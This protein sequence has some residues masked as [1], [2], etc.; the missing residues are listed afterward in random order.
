MSRHAL[1]FYL[2]YLMPLLGLLIVV[3]ALITTQVVRTQ[4][5]LLDRELE[6]SAATTASDLASRSEVSILL[7]DTTSLAAEL[8]RALSAN[9][10]AD[11]LS[12]LDSSGAVIVEFGSA[13]SLVGASRGPLPSPI[14]HVADHV[15]AVSLIRG[16]NGAL[17][18]ESVA[19]VRT[20][21]VRAVVRRATVRLL[22]VSAIG[23][24]AV[25]LSAG[26]LLRRIEVL[27]STLEQRVN[28][29]THD[30][31]QKTA[32]V[33][34]TALF[35][36]LNPSPVIRFD[37]Q[38]VIIWANTE[39][40]RLLDQFA[41]GDVSVSR[42]FPVLADLDLATLIDADL[43]ALRDVTH[44]QQTFQVSIRGVAAHNFGHAYFA[45]I[46][47]QKRSETALAD[48]RDRAL[49]ASRMK[50]QFLANM[51][52]E[53]RTPMNGVLGMLDLLST[54]VLT[55]KQGEFV[56]LASSSAHGLLIIINDILDFSK[57]EAGRMD[58]ERI[59]FDLRETVEAVA[60]LLAEPAHAKGL[61]LACCIAPEIPQ[62][63][64]GDSVRLRQ[65]LL[66]LG[67]NGVKFTASGVVR[68]DVE[69]PRR[70]RDHAHI[71]FAITDTGIGMSADTMDRLFEPFTQADS[72]TTR[73][74]GGTGLGLS[75]SR[76]L[77]EL[78][79]GVLRVDSTEGTGSTFQ[80]S[81]GMA[82]A[83][84]AEL[85]GGAPSLNGMRV[86]VVDDNEIR[87]DTL[88]RYLKSEGSLIA[89]ADCTANALAYLAGSPDALP[90]IVIV[91]E[92]LAEGGA[93]AL[94]RS[95][96]E[97]PR[98]AP[99]RMVQVAATGTDAN[100]SQHGA[101]F[102]AHIHSPLRYREM[103]ATL[104]ALRSSA[105][106]TPAP[107]FKTGET[108]HLATNSSLNGHNV[109]A[110][111][112]S[113]RVLLAEDNKVN[114]FLAVEILQYAGYLVD[115][116]ENGQEA[117]DARFGAEYAAILMDCQMPVMDGLSAARAIRARES[118]QR[119]SRIP[120]VAL[121]A[122]AQKEDLRA[123]MDAG[124]DAYLSKPYTPSA[125]LTTLH[126]TL[127]ARY[128]DESSNVSATPRGSR[129]SC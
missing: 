33:A 31:A 92:R 89:T 86:L 44:R 95:I 35:A 4:R 98:F 85:G 8:R 50:S 105:P 17:L 48:A 103:M 57:I 112:G 12:V 129:A 99:I 24:L 59:P 49:D 93:V 3:F 43:R 67:G 128:R 75:I 20:A 123:S 64:V 18:G 84:E 25:A 13:P 70:E 127:R 108:V 62:F 87:R 115:V 65:I 46:S 51:S 5:T 107:S 96:R 21:R 58:M 125:L 55:D 102:D 121:T 81:I 10:D 80:F 14:R 104:T 41:S 120:I 116:V 29:R 91:S 26:V 118:A 2:R 40:D 38:G 69:I 60:R 90:E 52:H 111:P 113:T 30:L 32:E 77:V 16:S 56:H 79:G 36:T 114:Q 66:N 72:S 28:E 117:V 73:K 68:I 88:S 22:L 119:M 1:R 7:G 6:R 27:A 42:A 124:M 83:P 122:S 47:A 37:R 71:R 100:D 15:I 63:V 61:S 110:P 106:G 74:F 9:S 109:M 94:A 126:G 101:P 78:M 45:D 34:S 82:L 53:I 76:H 23:F 19:Q 39:A 54:T 11:H 97:E